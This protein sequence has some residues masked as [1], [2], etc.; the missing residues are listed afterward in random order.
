MIMTHMQLRKLL[1]KLFPVDKLLI[2]DKGDSD[3]LR[4]SPPARIERA[5]K[6]ATVVKGYSDI[7]HLAA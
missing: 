5:N 6:M 4:A 3:I 1:N 2:K 7:K